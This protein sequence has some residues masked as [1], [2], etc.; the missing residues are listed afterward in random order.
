MPIVANHRRARAA[1]GPAAKGVFEDLLL[2]PLLRA[3][4]QKPI[5]RWF[6]S[7]A[8]IGVRLNRKEIGDDDAKLVANILISQHRGPVVIYDFG[9]YAR[10]HHAA[11]IREDRLIAGVYTLSELPEKLRARAILM[12]KLG[13]GC[14]F[15]DAVELAKYR[16]LRQTRRAK[17]IPIIGS[18][19]RVMA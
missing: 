13:K 7:G 16:K 9:C 18:S 1:F 4:L 2:S 15:E 19:T 11:L 3:A 12:P 5:P 6:Y 8:T 10:R 14:T 17:T